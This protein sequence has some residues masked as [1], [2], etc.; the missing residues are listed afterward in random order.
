MKNVRLFL[1]IQSILCV[2]LAL[3]MIAVVIGIYREGA[4]LR[5]DDPLAAIFTREIAAEAFS[6]IAPL[7][8]AA[9]GLAAV[10]LI[11]GVRDENSLKPAAG[12]KVENRAPGGKTV[13][14]VLLVAAV[15]LIVAGAF[16]GSARDVFGKAVK[17]CT[18]CVGLG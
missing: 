5:A 8:F 17:I 9:V 2:L 13:R 4:A 7:L 3:V 12:G 6:T 14:T 16:N 18:E 10:G 11:L 1:I 15:V